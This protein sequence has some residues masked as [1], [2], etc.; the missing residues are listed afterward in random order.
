MELSALEARIGQIQLEVVSAFQERHEAA[1]AEKILSAFNTL[2]NRMG[3]LSPSGRALLRAEMQLRLEGQEELLE[4]KPGTRRWE[5]IMAEWRQSSLRRQLKAQPTPA[6]SG[7][8]SP[9]SHT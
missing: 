6:R 7:E 2:F 5:L 9:T 4:A 1:E 3:S 8:A